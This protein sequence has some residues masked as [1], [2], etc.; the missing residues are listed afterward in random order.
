MVI[1]MKDLSS[2]KKVRR[3]LEIAREKQPEKP[4]V[5]DLSN[6]NFVW[7]YCLIL[8]ATSRPH[9]E[10]IVTELARKSKKE[11]MK[12]HHIEADEQKEWVLLDFGDV[13]AHIFSESKRTFYRLERLFK[14]AKKVRFRFS[15]K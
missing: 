6:S 9:A 3:L 1:M 5:L 8:T 4:V 7:D 2:R 13:A 12:P 10:A 11:K 14:G 15:R